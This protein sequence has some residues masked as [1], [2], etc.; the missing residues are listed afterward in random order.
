MVLGTWEVNGSHVY[1]TLSN[2]G[3]SILL[4]QLSTH[5]V[6]RVCLLLC[7]WVPP[8]LGALL[9]PQPKSFANAL[10]DRPYFPKIA[11]A[12]FS[13]PLNLSRSGPALTDGAQEK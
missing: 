12:A 4:A 9:Q 1:F 2:S 7:H 13:L 8:R 6:A 10:C 11:Q 5:G 3:R